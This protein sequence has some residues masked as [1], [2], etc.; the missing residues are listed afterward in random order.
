MFLRS[1]SVNLFQTIHILFINP[2]LLFGLIFLS[3][4][5]IILSIFIS[6]I[7]SFTRF[8]V[9]LMNSEAVPVSAT[10]LDVISTNTKINNKRVY[11]FPIKY[12]VQ[13]EEYEDKLMDHMNYYEKGEK[14]EIQVLQSDP[15]IY[16]K[17]LN[18]FESF[19]FSFLFLI[20]FPMIGIAVIVFNI[21]QKSKLI[22]LYKFGQLGKGTLIESKPANVTVNGS[23]LMKMVFE[24]SPNF[25]PK[26][27]INITG[28]I[29]KTYNY[30][31]I[32][33]KIENQLSV[34]V[35]MK[36]IKINSFGQELIKPVNQDFDILFKDGRGI[37]LDDR[38]PYKIEGDF[39]VLNKGHMGYGS[40]IFGVI[41]VLFI[42]FFIVGLILQET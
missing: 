30:E 32:K 2:V 12:E 4:G 38:Q 19:D 34:D 27:K 24:V 13:G 29:P 17:S 21:I 36:E 1:R 23:P 6:G 37:I 31:E 25:G 40:I 10:V 22:W 39:L 7:V 26:E 41:F 28:T 14:I 42:I 20:L 5:I 33:D 9:G 3:V 16:V 11:K 35:E 8:Q 18:V 15:E